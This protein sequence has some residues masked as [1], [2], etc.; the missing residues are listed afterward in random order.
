MLVGLHRRQRRQYTADRQS[1]AVISQL[2]T[3]GAW[4]MA[5]LDNSLVGSCDRAK[6][7]SLGGG[8]KV[9]RRNSHT[10]FWSPQLGSWLWS[11]S[12][13]QHVRVAHDP[14]RWRD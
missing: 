10:P 9:R 1:P 2:D 14:S 7:M 12:L 3:S 8:K 4:R 6:A 11:C 13:G 5:G